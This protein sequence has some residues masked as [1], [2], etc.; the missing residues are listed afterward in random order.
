MDA[1]RAINGESAPHVTVV[2]ADDH[3]VVRAGMRL[4]LSQD[5][6][7]DIVA[8]SA[9]LPD[10]LQAVEQHHPSV[11][12]LDLNLA[13]QSSLGSIPELQAAS[14]RTRILV[15]T[16]Q[17]DPAFAREAMRNGAAGYLLKEAAAE[18]LLGATRQVAAG[19][20]YVQPSL[21]ARLAVA[22]LHTPGAAADGALTVREGEVLSLLVLGHTNQ[23]IADRLHVSVR[24]VETHRA[25]IRNKLGAE[26]RAD[27]ITAARERGMLA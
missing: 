6:A 14:P 18:E 15:L 27:L 11:L 17:E 24:T 1:V 8:E 5:P 13:G 4:L 10:T 16:M 22:T 20:S 26:S 21:G 19:A 7:F 23:E 2:L 3:L 25:R 12:V 9:T